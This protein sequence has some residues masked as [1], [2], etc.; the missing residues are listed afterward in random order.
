MTDKTDNVYDALE[1]LFHEPNRLSIMSAVCA[2]DKGLS[3]NDLKAACN[4][5]DGNLNRHLK[6]LEEAR[7]VKIQKSFVDSKPRTTIS[8][9][10]HGLAR[11]TEYL[12][13][14]SEVLDK[15]RR[16]MPAGEKKDVPL[17]MGETVR[18]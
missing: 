3:F 16:T 9:S 6:V 4:L 11:F 2:A 17:A 8:L 10:Q 5:T 1:K 7:A 18:A 15:A 14:L 13:A 12:S